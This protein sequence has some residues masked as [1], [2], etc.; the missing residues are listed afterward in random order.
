MT[1]RC[2]FTVGDVH[3]WRAARARLAAACASSSWL[4]HEFGSWMVYGSGAQSFVVDDIF[5]VNKVFALDGT[6]ALVFAAGRSWC[7]RLRSWLRCCSWVAGGRDG[8]CRASNAN[9]YVA[10]GAAGWPNQ[11][12][13]RVFFF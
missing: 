9:G 8:P 1:T 6:D 7:S 5:K 11:D 10:G 3:L 12:R 4:H 2:M 13:L